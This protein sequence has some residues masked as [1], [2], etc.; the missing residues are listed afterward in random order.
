MTNLAGVPLHLEL[1][2]QLLAVIS[3]TVGF[4][5]P[6]VLVTLAPAELENSSIIADECNA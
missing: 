6:Y 2:M 4:S 3:L 5:K 1:L